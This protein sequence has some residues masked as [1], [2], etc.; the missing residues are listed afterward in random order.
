MFITFEGINGSGKS[1]Q[2]KMLFNYLQSIGK[3]VILTKEPGGGG[4]F[5]MQIRRLLCQTNDISKLTEMFLLF[6]ARKEHIDKLISPALSD[7]KIVICDRYIDSTFAYQ[8]CDDIEKTKLVWQL[9][10]EIGGLMPDKTFF[11]DISV[12]ESEYRLAPLLYSYI[13]DGNARN[14]YKKYDELTTEH[15]QKILNIYHKLAKDND[16]RIITIDGMQNIE[17]I[18]NQIIHELN[19]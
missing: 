10:N 3:D 15:M 4:D 12:Q 14:G 16:G 5:C 2:A 8:C 6:A 19:V 18:H 17:D 9:H 1:T 11:I 7:G 13:N